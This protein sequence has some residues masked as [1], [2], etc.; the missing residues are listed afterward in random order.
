MG[1]SIIVLRPTTMLSA[2][3][4]P[5]K[6]KTKWTR[7]VDEGGRSLRMDNSRGQFIFTKGMSQGSLRKKR[8]EETNQTMIDFGL[9]QVYKVSREPA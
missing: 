4:F 3:S 7:S 5:G 1:T 9:C 8:D 2:W 6:G